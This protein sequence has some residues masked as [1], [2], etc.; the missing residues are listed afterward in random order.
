MVMMAAAAGGATLAA[1][2]LSGGEIH[3]S[4]LAAIGG[5]AW[6]AHAAMIRH[7]GSN[8]KFGMPSYDSAAKNAQVPW[9]D[10]VR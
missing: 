9:I 4:A 5:P 10:S 3:R 8:A 2:T 7:E 6:R 1:L